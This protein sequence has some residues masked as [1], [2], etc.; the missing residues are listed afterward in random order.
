M[1]QGMP[2]HLDCRGRGCPTEVESLYDHFNLSGFHCFPEIG[3]I[4]E[5]RCP[6]F[7]G[8]L[9]S[10][11]GERVTYMNGLG[12]TVREISHREKVRRDDGTSVGGLIH[13]VDFAVRCRADYE[14][15]REEYTGNVK[16]RVG[17]EGFEE[18]AAVANAQGDFPVSFF[19]HGPFAFLRDVLGTEN[20]M[21]APYEDP[22][23]VRMM[24]RDHL[25]VCM[26]VAE[27]LTRK[28][29][30]DFSFVWEDCCGKS[31]PFMSPLIFDDAFAWWYREWKDFTVS[32]GVPWTNLDSDG[33][34]GPLIP[35][36]YECGIDLIHP[37]EVNGVDMLKFAEAYPKARMMGGIYKHMFEPLSLSQV[38][39]FDTADAYEAIDRELRRVVG[40][41]RKRGYYFPA[42]D[43]GAHW[44]IGYREYRHYCDRMMDYGKANTVTRAIRRA[45]TA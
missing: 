31:G 30:Y 27:P 43:H 42:L 21:A 24:L 29:R 17:M 36:W 32:V 35:Q 16:D 5:Y 11:D 12:N 38:G 1:D 34:V 15:L 40:P 14:G 22:A 45:P 33:N 26:A 41:M 3:S 7:V 39:R 19:V 37:W 18:G 23:W 13:E 4:N 25:N 44:E 28:V 6:P 8:G 10:D 20:A 2:T 9:Y